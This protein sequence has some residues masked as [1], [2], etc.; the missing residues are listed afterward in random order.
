MEKRLF[1]HDHMKIKLDM[2]SLLAVT[3]NYTETQIGRAGPL[4]QPLQ[5]ISSSSGLLNVGGDVNFLRQLSD[6]DFKTVL[7]IIQD[8]CIRLI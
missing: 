2:F 6:I 4:P 1:G 7:H 5:H 8:L 3:E